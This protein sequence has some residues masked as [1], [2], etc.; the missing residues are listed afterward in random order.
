[1]STKDM[2]FFVVLAVATVVYV[3]GLLKIKRRCHARDV[4]RDMFR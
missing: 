4:L 2:L 1:M 3:V